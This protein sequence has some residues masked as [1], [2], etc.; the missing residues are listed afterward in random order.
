MYVWAFIFILAIVFTFPHKNAFEM[1]D[2]PETP[3]TTLEIPET[4]EVVS[5]PIE[6]NQT[7]EV[8]A[9]TVSKIVSSTG[10]HRNND[11]KMPSVTQTGLKGISN[12][13]TPSITITEK[14]KDANI[15][16]K[17]ND[18]LKGKIIP[19]NVDWK[20]P[21]ID[22]WEASHI[23]PDEELDGPYFWDVSRKIL[24]KNYMSNSDAYYW[25]TV[26]G[27]W[28]DENGAQIELP[29]NI[30]MAI[31]VNPTIKFTPKF[32]SESCSSYIVPYQEDEETL[33]KEGVKNKTGK[34]FYPG[35]SYVNPGKWDVPQKRPPVCLTS[36]SNKNMPSATFTSGTPINV[37]ELDKTGKIAMT[38]EDVTQTN[39]G[40][41]MP[42]FKFQT[43]DQ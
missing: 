3:I 41:I 23:L 12:I 20:T 35:Y 27:F 11:D 10:Y 21:K 36:Y 39:V 2:I 14:N 1:F 33:F 43:I 42:K 5:A 26:Y 16:F 32:K 40:S 24:T 13:F 29:E 30:K 28:A 8:D 34:D 9:E 37:L 18:K 31:G 17:V 7:T 38:E 15:N 22:I 19:D 25:N 4:P 6:V